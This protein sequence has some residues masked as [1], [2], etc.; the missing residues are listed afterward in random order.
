MKS[1]DLLRKTGFF[2]TVR[3]ASTFVAPRKRRQDL[4][5][6]VDK[7]KDN[8]SSI[9]TSISWRRTGKAVLRSFKGM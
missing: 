9:P 3:T 6:C 1:S 7:Q 5:K 8:M 4:L 2:V